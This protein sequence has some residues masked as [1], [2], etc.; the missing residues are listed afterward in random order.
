DSGAPSSTAGNA[1]AGSSSATAGGGNAVGGIDSPTS[2]AQAASS[3]GCAVPGQNAAERGRPAFVLLLG[4]TLLR[5]R[6]Q[7]E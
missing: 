3:C 4:L 1:S 7:A 6:R 5:R 2:A